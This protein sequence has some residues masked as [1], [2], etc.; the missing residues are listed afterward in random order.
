MR[1]GQAQPCSPVVCG[2]WWS[3]GHPAPSAAFPFPLEVAL[4]EVTEMWA[5]AEFSTTSVGLVQASLWDQGSLHSIQA[6]TSLIRGKFGQAWRRT[7]ILT[8]PEGTEMSVLLFYQ[9]PTKYNPLGR[10]REEE[11]AHRE[12]RQAVIEAFL[13]LGEK[14]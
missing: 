14:F 3:A 8:P 10:A 2:V 11:E 5:Q 12:A 4:Q 7:Q 9:L 13:C 1:P 6:M